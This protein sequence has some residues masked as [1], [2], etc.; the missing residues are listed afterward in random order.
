M[1]TEHDAQDRV[2]PPETCRRL[3]LP[4]ER[5]DTQIC[6]RPMLVL[7]YV[8]HVDSARPV[9]L[10]PPFHTGHLGFVSDTPAQVGL[11]AD[12]EHARHCEVVVATFTQEWGLLA[13]ITV[14][15]KDEPGV[16]ARLLSAVAELGINIET[17]ESSG[18]DRLNHH[19]VHLTVDLSESQT[20]SGGDP[21]Q[22][23]KTP[24]PPPGV[25]RAYRHFASLFPIHNER[26]VRLFESI[27][28]H[29]ADV[30]V[31][32]D[33]SG[34]AFPDLSIRPMP[35]RRFSRAETVLLRSDN[36]RNIVVAIPPSVTHR[37]HAHLGTT[38]G[39][40]LACI[41]L[42]D[43]DTRSL[44][45]FFIDPESA[46]SLF[47]VGF[48]HNDV[49]G[50]LATILG[51]VRAADFNIL[52]SLSRKRPDGRAM[53]EALLEYR[54]TA[55]ESASSDGRLAHSP[56]S[57]PELEWLRD[58]IATAKPPDMPIVDCDITLDRPRYPRRQAAEA[59][60]AVSLSDDL[61]GSPH[62]RPP[63]CD[64]DMQRLVS[65]RR[66]AIARSPVT[67]P[68]APH[69]NGLL[70]IIQQTCSEGGRSTIFM[71]YPHG[72]AAQAGALKE[73]L[74]STNLYRVAVYQVPDGEVIVEKV[75]QMIEDSDYFI[76]LWH[77]E[78]GSAN[79]G[80]S[81]SL[82]PWMLFEYGIARSAGKPNV[83]LHS[84]H[85]DPS[86]WNRVDPGV[87]HP[88]YD[89]VSFAS[90]TVPAVLEYCRRHFA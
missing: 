80:I 52:T 38:S 9:L 86:V 28:A 37:I 10:V 24:T 83:I 29:C 53:W 39:S 58:T 35:A 87:A 56:L 25:S 4:W 36:K 75:L 15:M 23:R 14:T 8:R 1:P 43:T 74:E 69:R 67:D 5:S 90:K 65:A 16:V 73:G 19:Y 54:G 63:R 55:P 57:Q 70:D 50:A 66:A 33:I 76:G 40:P 47:H 21:L 79:D 12:P 18:I 27:I 82:S 88:S 51:L 60:H 46:L 13:S 17:Q 84:E 81:R 78:D 61:T 59:V 26:F 45:A 64:L 68:Y 42:S 44:R 3:I 71:S 49:P 72:A 32:R 7:D 30:I 6:S 34:Q 11:V 2:L 62:R 85:L 20:I 89:D 48:E 22:P 77:P 41:L 31:W